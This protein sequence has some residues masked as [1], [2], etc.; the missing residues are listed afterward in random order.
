MQVV[1]PKVYLI[2]S[3]QLCRP[4]LNEYFKDIGAS[5]WFTSNTEERDG[6]L[7]PE[8]AGRL[9]YRSFGTELNKN[10]T[11]VR[12]GNYKY[13]S[14][15]LASKHGSVLE[16]C[17]VSFILHNVSRVFTHE[18]VRHRVGTAI[19][20]E[21][22]RYV[23]LDELKAWL[24]SVFDQ[25]DRTFVRNIFSELEKS[26]TK[27]ESKHEEL[28]KGRSF[29]LKK[30]L[31]SALR[32]FMPSGMATSLL[33]SANFRTLLNVVDMRTSPHAE[34]EIQL[35]FNQIAKECLH[36]WPN[37]FQAWERQEQSNGYIHYSLPNGRI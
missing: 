28:F 21:S 9:C 20:Q 1:T 31:T 25:E 33:W 26:Y 32:R 12:Q 13:L 30:K 5:E 27:I 8:I 2:A 19:S 10:I 6:Q 36:R 4:S 15:V 24:P 14:N 29:S 17:Q 11:R 18:L 7:L 23:R 3:T 35:V 34:E 16:H 22:L 37:I